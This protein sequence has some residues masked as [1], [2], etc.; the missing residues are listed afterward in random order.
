M[1]LGQFSYVQAL[2]THFLDEDP[3]EALEEGGEDSSHESTMAD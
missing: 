1:A 2:Q 3:Q